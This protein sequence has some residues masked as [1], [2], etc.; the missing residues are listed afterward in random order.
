MKKG[1]EGKDFII[2]NSRYIFLL[3]ILITFLIINLS[4]FLMEIMV[5]KQ[6]H[7]SKSYVKWIALGYG[8]QGIQV[9]F[10]Q[11][12]TFHKK[13]HFLSFITLLTLIIK[14]ITSYSLINIFGVIGAAWSTFICFLF[15]TL[16]I[17]IYS[18]ILEKEH[19]FK[20]FNLNIN[21]ML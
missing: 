11:Y 18:A 17:I 20:L 6:Y 21:R 10:I 16:G 14:L 2:K 8:I 4:P 12:I 19:V 5:D 9:I 15:P 13:T 7:E 3:V 1:D